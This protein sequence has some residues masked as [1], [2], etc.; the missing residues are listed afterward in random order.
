MI[1]AV[2]TLQYLLGIICLLSLLSGCWSSTEINDNAFVTAVFI[3]KGQDG[4]I[5]LSLGFPLP[6]RMIPGEMGGKV[7]GNIYTLVTKEDKNIAAAYRKVQAELPRHISWGHTRLIIF[8]KAFAEEGIYEALEFFSRQPTFHTKTLIFIAPG[9]AR[10]IAELTPAFER[11]P[12]EVIQGFVEL[13]LTVRTSV[14]DFL[15]VYNFGGN[16]LVPILTIGEDPLI[17]E[18]GSVSTW[19]GTGGTALFQD[20]KLVGELSQG[21]MRGALWFQRITREAVITIDSFTDGKPISII[22]LE[23]KIKKRPVVKENGELAFQLEIEAKDDLISVDSDIEVTDPIILQQ[24]EEKFA[25][26]IEE[27]I[28]QTFKKTQELGADVFN[29]G[30]YFD[31]YYPK[32]WEKLRENWPEYY[33]EIELESLITIKIKRPGST[34]NPPWT[35]HKSP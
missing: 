7:E 11:F 8:S 27:R 10:E 22:V 4:N 17:S 21:E 12:S 20:G 33:K 1:K 30:E 3:D 13:D 5:S 31:W 32:E 23:S 16:M 29:L 35:K 19:V 28:Q 25:E 14:V 15:K 6:S 18:E 26:A 2:K 34:R 24:L 9:K